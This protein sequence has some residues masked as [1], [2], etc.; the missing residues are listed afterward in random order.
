MP[1]GTKLIFAAHFCRLE[2][3]A[4]LSAPIGLQGRREKY[5]MPIL[6]ESV[7]I[8][9]NF[10]GV[11]PLGLSKNTDYKSVNIGKKIRFSK[12]E[13]GGFDKE[14]LVNNYSVNCHFDENYAFDNLL[15]SKIEP[16]L[17]LLMAFEETLASQKNHLLPQF[18]T[19]HLPNP[20]QAW[21]GRMLDGDK[22]FSAQKL[23]ESHLILDAF[24]QNAQTAAAAKNPKAL[25]KSIETVVKAFNKLNQLNQYFIETDE[26]EELAPYILNVAKAA[27]LQFDSA[28]DL[29]ETWRGW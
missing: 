16:K 3:N 25:Y 11:W 20:V 4:A 22:Q 7:H 29:T 1:D 9:S 2:D 23:D 12:N 26:R 17:L 18:S 10:D 14:F 13:Y 21:H 19:S 8:L 27:G 24:L 15:I 28:L 5:D 6:I